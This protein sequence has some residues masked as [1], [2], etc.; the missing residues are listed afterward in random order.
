MSGHL[1][2]ILLQS[3]DLLAEGDK[4]VESV[5]SSSIFLPSTPTKS[6]GLCGSRLSI[7]SSST[8]SSVIPLRTA[9]P[10]AVLSQGRGP[11]TLFWLYHL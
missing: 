2:S 4:A 5:G 3:V 7:A 10:S 6:V 11:R 8:R 1:L 9:C